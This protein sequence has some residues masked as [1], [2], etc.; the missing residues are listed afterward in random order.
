MLVFI[1]HFHKKLC[2]KEFFCR[3]RKKHFFYPIVIR[4]FFEPYPDRNRESQFLLL[5]SL[6]ADHLFCRPAKCHFCLRCSHFIMQRQCLGKLQYFFIQKRDTHFQ[7][8]GHSHLIPL[9]QN[10]M[11]QPEMHIHILHLGHR[12]L[13]FHALIQWCSHLLNS[14]LAAFFQNTVRFSLCKNIRRIGKITFFQSFSVTHQEASSFHASW[15]ASLCKI[16]KHSSDRHWNFIKRSM[17]Q[18]LTVN[19]ISSEQFI[20]TFSGQHYLYLLRCF[21]TQ[22]IKCDRRRI[23]HR[24]IHII[25]DIGQII[26]VFLWS[27]DFC[28]IFHVDACCKLFRILNLAVFS[29][30]ESNGKGTIHLT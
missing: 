8:I 2:I 18:R 28:I 24:F 29:F 25:L 12:I 10:I 11:Y 16:S 19:I 17:L 4:I 7:R 13:V 26:P 21:L 23:C 20:R 6:T 1:Q 3:I 22:K 15:K 30:V 27:D 14:R 5:C 9:H